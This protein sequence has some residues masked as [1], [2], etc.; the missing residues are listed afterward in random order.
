M[1]KIKNKRIKIR[2]NID[3][4]D[5][6]K[7]EKYIENYSNIDEIKST[8]MRIF[9][10]SSYTVDKITKSFT[11]SDITY[12]VKDVKEFI[13]YMQNIED[14]YNQH[15]KLSEKIKKFNEINITRVEYDRIHCKQDNVEEI[16][17][18]INSIKVKISKKINEQEILK[19]INIEKD[20]EK[21][22]LFAKDI[23]LLKSMITVNNNFIEESYDIDSKIKTLS[24]KIPNYIDYSY[25]KSNKGSVEYHNHIKSYIPRMKRLIKNIDKYLKFE[26]D[27]CKINQSEALLDSL[28]IAV[29]EFNN[30]EFKAIS[31]GTDI[32]GFCTVT[33]KDKSFFES[34][35]VNKLGELGIGYNRINDSE[36]KILEEIHRQIKK[37]E[38]KNTGRLTLYT[39]WEPCPSCYYVIKQFSDLYP[40]IN[41]DVKYEKNYG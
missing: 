2:N 29:G 16:L 9:G 1:K 20:L 11:N 8:L 17:K 27:V 6:L 10:I 40:N 24:I 3:F 23:E 35:K 41:I 15:N 39:R 19:L 30:I 4:I 21:E 18:Q 26:D 34:K 33:S 5:A 38:L 31:G 13:D 14:F 36:K 22:Y 7:K 28:N 12:K 37:G 32:K 25:I